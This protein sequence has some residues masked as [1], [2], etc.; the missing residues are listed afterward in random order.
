MQL[1]KFSPKRLDLFE[2]LKSPK[3]PTPKDRYGPVYL[4]AIELAYSEIER[5]FEQSDLA[6]IKDLETLL[7][8]AANGKDI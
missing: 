1:I 7:L 2:S 6:R 4:E 3:Y 5:R 8:S